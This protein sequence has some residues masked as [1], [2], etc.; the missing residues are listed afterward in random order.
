MKIN[1]NI[2]RNKEI[3]LKKLKKESIF[4]KI[5]VKINKNTGLNDQNNVFN[6]INTNVVFSS[7]PQTRSH[8]NYHGLGPRPLGRPRPLTLSM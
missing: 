6:T 7:S 1:T 3:K 8:P 4:L 2:R 5:Y